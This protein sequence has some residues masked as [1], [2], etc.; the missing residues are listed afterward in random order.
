MKQIKWLNIISWTILSVV[1][2]TYFIN[3]LANKFDYEFIKLYF[4]FYAYPFL[5]LVILY[6]CLY[7]L[8]IKSKI[9]EQDMN[10]LQRVMKTLDKNILERIT[11][12]YSVSLGFNI[13][14]SIMIENFLYNYEHVDNQIYKKS[15]KKLLDIFAVSLRSFYSIFSDS[16][17]AINNKVVIYPELKM[18]NPDKYYKIIKEL[19]ELGNIVYKDLKKLIKYCKL[20]GQSIY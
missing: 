4:H 14:T 6:L 2:L 16:A 1:F 18:T 7:L 5:L 12:T 8:F 10:S 13:N 20:R 9:P 15:L 11:H 3:V 17:T 19:D